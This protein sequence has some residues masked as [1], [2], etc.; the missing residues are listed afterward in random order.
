M[1]PSLFPVFGLTL[2]PL[3]IPF[4]LC[5]QDLIKNLTSGNSAAP[6]FERQFLDD[7]VKE[8]TNFRGAFEQLMELLAGFKTSE[9]A[10]LLKRALKAI[11]EMNSTMSL[12]QDVR[13]HP[14]LNG[15]RPSRFLRVLLSHR[16]SGC[17]ILLNSSLL[18]R[19]A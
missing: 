14:F 15:L 3:P 16:R 10:A 13:R 1:S 17:N 19:G 7:M 8:M 6:E 18:R 12:Y 5:A 2:Q 9:A 4:Q 11:D